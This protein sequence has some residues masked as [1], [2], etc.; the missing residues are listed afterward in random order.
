MIVNLNYNNNYQ[1]RELIIKTALN[2]YLIKLIE[3]KME[4][5]IK[6]NKLINN[7]INIS[8]LLVNKILKEFENENIHWQA[9]TQS[10]KRIEYVYGALKTYLSEINEIKSNIDNKINLSMT[11]LAKE[12]ES[13]TTVIDFIK[14]L[15]DKHFRMNL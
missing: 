14:E 10:E 3:L 11:N 8:I 13:V 2:R 12:V 5:Y 4:S 9:I 7:D 6:E 15:G 1:N